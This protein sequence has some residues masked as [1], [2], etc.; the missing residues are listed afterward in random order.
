LTLRE[1]RLREEL[2]DGGG[3]RNFPISERNFPTSER[4]FSTLKK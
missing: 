1:R 4:Y 2:L 3:E